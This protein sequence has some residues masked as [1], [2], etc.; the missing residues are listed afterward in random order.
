MG[1]EM[2]LGT[3]R[4]HILNDPWGDRAIPVRFDQPVESAEQLATLKV[5]GIVAVGDK[6]ALIA[7]TLALIIPGKAKAV[8]TGAPR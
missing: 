2:I 4:C 1:I 6:P 7:E 8:E 5:D 3:D